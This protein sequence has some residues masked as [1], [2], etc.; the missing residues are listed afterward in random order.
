MSFSP[1]VTSQL[2]SVQTMSDALVE[3]DE[4]FDGVLTLLPGSERILLGDDRAMATIQDNSSKLGLYLRA[5][6]LCLC[7]DF[8]N[9]DILDDETPSRT[10]YNILNRITIT[11]N[12]Y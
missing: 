5:W 7:N 6:Q 8:S 4:L 3:G 2:V 9:T 11:G 12:H 10:I 1:G